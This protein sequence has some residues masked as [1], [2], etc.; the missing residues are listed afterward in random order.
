MPS[1]KE[2]TDSMTR[3]FPKL[4]VRND[5]LSK[6][7]KQ[8]Q[9]HN[10]CFCCC[11]RVGDEEIPCT[12][13]ALLVMRLHVHSSS[14]RSLLSRD[15][16]RCSGELEAIVGGSGMQIY[17]MHAVYAEGWNKDSSVIKLS[18]SVQGYRGECSLRDDIL[19][20]N[21]RKECTLDSTT[22]SDEMCYFVL[23]CFP[24]PF[25]ADREAAG[26]CGVGDSW[27]FYYVW[28]Q[29]GP[30]RPHSSPQCPAFDFEL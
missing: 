8:K 10:I 19:C 4:D 6:I 3:F 12:T 13:C 23:F 11:P 24:L 5:N 22:G 30:F 7:E 20:R 15:G 17:S 29:V 18:S 16:H 1:D 21:T 28:R 9:E 26:F 25:I 2:F 14:L 27:V